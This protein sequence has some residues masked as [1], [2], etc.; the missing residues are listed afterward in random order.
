MKALVFGSYAEYLS[1][2][3]KIVTGELV[4]NIAKLDGGIKAFLVDS[5]LSI[6]FLDW[7]YEIVPPELENESV[8]AIKLYLAL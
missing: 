3:N 2:D 7:E 8:E 5:E 4:P 6:F 1:L